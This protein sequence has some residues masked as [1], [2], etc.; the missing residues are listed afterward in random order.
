MPEWWRDY[1][2]NLVLE[3]PA[4]PIFLF[5]ERKLCSEPEPSLTTIRWPF[6]F[7]DV[8]DHCVMIFMLFLICEG[9]QREFHSQNLPGHDEWMHAGSCVGILFPLPQHVHDFVCSVVTLD[10]VDGKRFISLLSVLA[11]KRLEELN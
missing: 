2:P 6:R 9:P 10:L 7:A 11:I 1:I 4:S 3:V 5:P 8:A